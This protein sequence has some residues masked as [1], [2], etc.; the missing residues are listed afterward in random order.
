MLAFSILTLL[1]L[2]HPY[3]PFITEEIYNK[4]RT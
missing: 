2:W 1:K 3:V 4:L